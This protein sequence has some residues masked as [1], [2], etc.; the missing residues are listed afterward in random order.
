LQTIAR[1]ERR[2]A[3]VAYGP[4][5]NESWTAFFSSNRL[6]R[7]SNRVNWDSS[8]V[9]ER[10]GRRATLDQGC[11]TALQCLP[12]SQ[13]SRGVQVKFILTAFL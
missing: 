13:Q 1:E 7:T 12:K 2:P 8:A 9:F 6:Q 10:S 11:P 5:A 4:D 3:F